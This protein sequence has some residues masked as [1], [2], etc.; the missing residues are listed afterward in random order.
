MILTCIAEAGGLSIEKK[1]RKCEFDRRCFLENTSY[2]LLSEELHGSQSVLGSC[3]RVFLYRE[4][5][6]IPKI[7]GGMA[8]RGCRWPLW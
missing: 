4:T 3:L 2:Q 1:E 6:C 5:V 7:G 8:Y